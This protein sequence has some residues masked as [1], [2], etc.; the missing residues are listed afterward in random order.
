MFLGT[1]IERDNALL[2]LTSSVLTQMK[3]IA[4]ENDLLVGFQ[5]AEHCKPKEPLC[6]ALSVEDA[7]KE[8]ISLKQGLK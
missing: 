4:D 7:I 8:L 2:E 5:E 6:P 3:E 1:T